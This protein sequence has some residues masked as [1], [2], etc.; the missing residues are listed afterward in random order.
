MS[1]NFKLPNPSDYNVYVPSTILRSLDLYLNHGIDA[2][3]FCMSLLMNDLKGSFAYA[4]S[5][6]R[7][8][9][10]EYVQYLYWAMPSVAWGSEEKVNAWMKHQGFAGRNSQDD[11]TE[12]TANY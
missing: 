4:D 3:S 6:N 1:T 12:S 10:G 2:G 11:S 7:D 8:H 5:Y 9:I